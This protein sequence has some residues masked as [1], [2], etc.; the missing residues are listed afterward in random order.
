MVM[1]AI[2]R[3]KA[4]ADQ[5]RRKLDDLPDDVIVLT[6]AEAEQIQRALSDVHKERV[7]RPQDAD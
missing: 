4:M 3:A 6:R 1:G 7:R 5:L 2:V